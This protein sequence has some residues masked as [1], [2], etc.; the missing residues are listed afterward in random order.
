MERHKDIT[1]ITTVLLLAFSLLGT[2]GLLAV[3]L[4]ASVAEAKPASVLLQEGLYAEEIEGDLDAAIRIYEQ[5]IAEVRAAR[6]T[7]AQATYRLGMCYLKK[8]EKE[9]AVEQFRKLVSKFPQQESLVARAREQLA[10][11]KPSVTTTAAVFGP[12]IERVVFSEA[13][14]RD[15]FFDLDTA[16]AFSPPP[17]L[18]RQSP[19]QKVIDWGRSK[20][21]D[22][23]NDGG[24][25]DLLEMKAVEVPQQMW[26]S[27]RPD[28][29]KDALE[30]GFP[31]K[32]LPSQSQFPNYTISSP[33]TYAFK[34]REG[35]MG[36]LQILG[37]TEGEPRGVRFRYKMVQGGVYGGAMARSQELARRVASAKKLS[38]LGKALLVCANDAEGDKFPDALRELVEG[39]YWSTKHFEWALENVAY[40]GKGKRAGQPDMVL[41][42]DRTILQR[43][44]GTNVLFSDTHVQF[45]Q[46][47]KLEELGI[48]PTGRAY[49]FGPAE[50]LPVDELIKSGRVPAFKCVIYDNSAL[51]LETG[52]AVLLPNER[53]RAESL[54]V[55]AVPQAKWP[56]GFDVA[57]DNDGGGA[58]MVGPGSGA[59]IVGLP[60]AKK[61][62]WEEA[63]S[64]ARR[65]LGV[66]RTSTAKGILARQSSYA[67]VLT[68]E[69]NLAI[70]E[71]GDYDA[72][73]A[74]L[75]WWVEKPEV[76]TRKVF[77]PDEDTGG[78]VVL[79]LASGELLPAGEY[80]RLGFIPEH[81]KGDLTY[82]NQFRGGKAGEI[83]YK[84]GLFCLRGAKAK[85][86]KKDG[87][88]EPQIVLDYEGTTGYLLP[89]FPCRL[90]VTTAEGDDYEV[91]VKSAAEGGVNLEYERSGV[92]KADKQASENLAADG[93][94]LWHRRE[95]AEAE[96]KFK[97]AVEKDPTNA[98]AWNGLGWS[99][100]NQGK[101]LNAKV[102]FEKC[103]E[104]E[105][106]HAAA[107]NGLGW[108]AKGQGKTDE[109]IRHWKSA[110]RT[111]P[112]ATAALNGLATTYMEL[113]KYDEAAQYYKTWLRIEPDN[114]E[115]KA[116][117]AKAR[118]F[119]KLDLSTPEA[120]VIAFTKAAAAGE[121]DLALA[122]FAPDSYDYEDAKVLLTGPVTNPL[123]M[124]LDAVDPDAPI[125]IVALKTTDDTRCSIKW[126]MVLK[127]GFTVKGETFKP[128]DTFD[129]D[130]NLK[131]VEDRWL[132]VGI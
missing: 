36:V 126:R 62:R 41:A 18:T 108:I 9:K 104:I 124:M 50:P 61:E 79:D 48:R 25:L 35:N 51:D 23:V 52:A 45:V 114:T 111:A 68:S 110:L 120:T 107:L 37:F 122:C 44:E 129:L 56:E 4:F 105:P 112:N 49:G 8:G 30:K 57:W 6:Q 15:F 97:E 67:A 98:D 85:I 76:K 78:N 71:I 132:I 55:R 47:D 130:G 94:K 16:S 116:G 99:Q 75:Y 32:I 65:T 121:V 82:D 17:G 2:S 1:G 64:T 7:A 70:V 95:L 84:D 101:P 100:F 10:K 117:L 34:T 77:L 119:A 87:F 60:G 73:K 81:G 26:D 92:S 69:G 21:I 27:A 102:S 80:A 90:V 31:A 74:T 123:R 128:G 28:E 20:G 83:A 106:K 93:W 59:R 118:T 24:K 53:P 103:L 58:L 5:V 115:T 127:K 96:Q 42:Y 91:T 46:P 109:A 40:L 19:P 13:V 39:D 22:F 72:E 38:Y 29:V 66:L 86:W 43:G 63:I 88:A 113:G 89:T 125:Q 3:M 54:I 131:K 14:G 33:F 11:L 12:V